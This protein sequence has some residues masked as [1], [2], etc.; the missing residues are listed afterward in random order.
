M[1]SFSGSIDRAINKY[2]DSGEVARSVY[3]ISKPILTAEVSGFAY[4]VIIE[5]GYGNMVKELPVGAAWQVRVRF[6]LLRKLEHFIIALGIGSSDVGIRTAW[7]PERDLEEGD[8]EA[9]FKEDQLLLSEGSYQLT[10]G[11]SSFERT[12]H[13]T[14]NAATIAI[15]NIPDPALDKS[16]VRTS[17]TGLLLNPMHVTVSSLSGI[18]R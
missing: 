5:D 8:Y 14:E 12:I 2:V 4:R 10:I 6:V 9:V 11:L 13:Y 3:D 7:S 17:G 15:S 1:V 18:L 16:I